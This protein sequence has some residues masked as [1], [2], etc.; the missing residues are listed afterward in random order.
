MS[1]SDVSQ[2]RTT[3]LNTETTDYTAGEEPWNK[4]IDGF[5]IPKES[6]ESS[7]Y[8]AD[9]TKWHGIYRN[10]PEIRSTIDTHCK[11]IIGKKLKLGDAKTKE[12]NKRVKGIGK[13]TLRKILLNIKRVSKICGD[14]YAWAPRDKAGRLLNLKILDSGTIEIQ[15]DEFGI[16]KKYVQV[17]TKNDSSKLRIMTKVEDKKILDEFEPKDIFHISNERIGDEIHGIP[18][19]EKLQK[20]IKITQQGI[21]DYTTILHRFGKPTFFYEA[22]TDDDTE[23][24]D[25]KD[26][27]DKAQKNFEN[28][29]IPKDTL[30]NI[31]KVAVAQFSMPDPMPWLNFIRNYFSESSGVPDIVR[32]RSK[33]VSLAA[34]K[35]EYLGFKEKIE[36][37]QIEFSEDIEMQL[38]LKISF[39]P[40]QD[41]DI[42]VAK[43]SESMSRKIN[44]KEGKTIMSGENPNNP[45][46]NAKIK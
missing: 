46:N 10:I 30:N 8:Q 16:I 24:D 28:I 14:C 33:E 22:N 25:I 36:M 3:A 5:N 27:I 7:T 6:T 45:R 13:D 15:A 19:T 29:V 41:I 17:S 4:N 44:A 39:E 11:W 35:L 9:W 2:I 12:F 38:G 34:G 40:P 32:G 26:K 31:E 20:I 1:L 37:E 18:D 23:L 42:E 21:M 43:T